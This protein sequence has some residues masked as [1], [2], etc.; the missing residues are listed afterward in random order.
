MHVL[1]YH[2][3]CNSWFSLRVADNF[4]MCLIILILLTLLVSIII[5]VQLKKQP[6]LFKQSPNSL[7]HKTMWFDFTGTLY[8]HWFPKIDFEIWAN[9]SQIL[10]RIISQHPNQNC[11]ITMLNFWILVLHVKSGYKIEWFTKNSWLKNCLIT[12]IAITIKF[13]A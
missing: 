11:K 8:F 5:H 7:H 9:H 2:L 6:T 1:K 13:I 10:P 3:K 12:F 4:F